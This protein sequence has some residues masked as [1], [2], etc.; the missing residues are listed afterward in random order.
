MTYIIIGP[1]GSGKTTARKHMEAMGYKGFEAS[2][3]ARR[4]MK[5]NQDSDMGT[6]LDR[7][8]HDIVARQILSRMGRFP[9]VIS[10]FRTPE[11]I[12]C[13]RQAGPIRV[14]YIETD[15][16]TCFKR[17]QERDGGHY[18]SFSDFVEKKVRSDERLGLTAARRMVDT[19]VDN[20]GG[21]DAF[22]TQIESVCEV[23]E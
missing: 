14:L 15:I 1:G 17:V 21:I 23:E 4:L 5:E 12:E 16:K 7:L 22:L 19:V 10:G 3:Y 11:E 6:I 20:S 8:G 2:E 13:I 18:G 9:Y